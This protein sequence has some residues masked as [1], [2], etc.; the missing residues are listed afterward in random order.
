MRKLQSPQIPECI[1]R[2]KRN[3]KE[4]VDWMGSNIIPKNIFKCHLRGKRILDDDD[5][6]DDKQIF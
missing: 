1:K 6:G 5:G 3:W 2:Y 4:H